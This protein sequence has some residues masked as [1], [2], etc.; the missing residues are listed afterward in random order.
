MA[1]DNRDEREKPALTP[2]EMKAARIRLG[3]SQAELGS[4][5]GVGKKH[6]SRMEN[7]SIGHAEW[8]PVRE[9]TARLLQAYLGGYRPIDWPENPK[10]P[11][12]KRLY[13][14]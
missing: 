8:R 2:V 1:D 9:Q 11:Q 4:M 10:G 12:A 14:R 5:L 7:R 3:L 6:V 13:T